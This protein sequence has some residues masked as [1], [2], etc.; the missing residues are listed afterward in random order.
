M[1]DV[2]KVMKRASGSKMPEGWLGSLAYK[3]AFWYPSGHIPTGRKIHNSHRLFRHVAV[4]L[5]AGRLMSPEKKVI[6]KTDFDLPNATHCST[7]RSWQG[8]VALSSCNT[9]HRNP[10]H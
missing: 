5:I 9:A 1:A 7:S 2:A 3:P 4:P 6:P 8:S 10:Q